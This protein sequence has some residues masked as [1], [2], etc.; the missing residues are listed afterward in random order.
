MERGVRINP[1]LL[2]GLAVLATLVTPAAASD[3]GVSLRWLGVAGFTI[4]DA[5]GAILHDPYMSRPGLLETVFTWYRPD[6]QVLS[7]LLGP[8]S[9]APEMARADLIL[10]GH[11]HF[12]HLGD[13]PWIAQRTGAT[14]AGSRTSVMLS[15][16]YGVAEA[17]TRQV[18]AGDVWNHGSFEIRVIESRHARVLFGEVPLE[19]EVDEPPEAPVH[20]LSFPLGD[21]RSY[22]VT[23]RP[24]GIRIFTLSSAD[25]H[26]PALE[27]LR[28]EGI[29][30]D[31][32]LAAIMGR[33]PDFAR[34]LVVALEPRIV[35]PHHFEDFFT[36]LDDPEA[37]APRNPE[38]LAAFEDEIHRAAADAGV[39]VEVRRLDLFGVLDVSASH[40]RRSGP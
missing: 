39:D 35:V 4:A 19:G 16:A 38:D 37:V 14:V 24:S 3:T 7:P 12:D 26:A 28:R 32:L 25:R 13:A 21:A 29:Q 31:V 9:P 1:V 36:A 20:V 6:P 30:V 40:R 11:S 33:D 22:L 23:H 17:R 8:G 34:D 18:D 15:R 2:A 10:I 5:D 27:A